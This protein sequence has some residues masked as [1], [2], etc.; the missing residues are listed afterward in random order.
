MRFS[1]KGQSVSPSASALR[2]FRRF[3]HHPHSV[4]AGF[5]CHSAYNEQARPVPSVWKG[6]G[7]TVMTSFFQRKITKDQSRDTGMAVVLLL[8]L[9]DLKLKRNGILFGAMAVHVVNMIWPRVYQPLAY[10]W[11]GLSDLLGNVTSKILMSVLFFG[12]VTP[13]GMLR[14]LLGKDS[15]Q[16]RA[17]KASNGSSL[18]VRNHVFIA[19]D[20]E[21]PY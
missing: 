5:H 2:Q 1:P 6:A 9:I 15:L 12:V 7:A 4:E 20:V 10:F 8:L 17:F 19:R 16:L 21:R 11:F 13:I 18:T 3:R 14:R